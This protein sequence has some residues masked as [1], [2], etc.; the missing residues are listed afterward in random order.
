MLEEPVFSVSRVEEDG[1]SMFLNIV[2]HLTDYMTF[3]PAK[4]MAVIPL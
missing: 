1:G 3:H 4:N 2:T